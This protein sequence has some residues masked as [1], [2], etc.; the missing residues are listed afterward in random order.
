VDKLTA[1]EVVDQLPPGWALLVDG[2]HTRVATDDFAV[3]LA[4][5]A[6]V[7]AAAGQQGHFPDLTLRTDAVDVRLSTA[8]VHG[9]T[10]ADLQLAAEI[11]RL[12]T[13]AGLTAGT[14]GTSRLEL[15]LDSPDLDAIAGFWAAV[16][17]SEHQA[18]TDYA[19]EVRDPSNALP[20]VW[21][22]PSGSEE[23]RQRWHPDVWVDPTEVQ[24]RI[25]AA[26]AAG[27]ALVSDAEAPAFWVLADPQGNQVCLCTW[28]GRA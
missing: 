17:A 23:P 6:Q 27:G 22:Q 20:T 25:D 26:L 12:V 1:P 10:A 16:L 18:G 3:G 24:P 21:F 15:G 8:E 28:Q 19:D 13:D 4:L 5:V 9:V 2:L 14:R 11:T 7:G